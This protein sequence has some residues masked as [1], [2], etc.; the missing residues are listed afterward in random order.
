MIGLNQGNVQRYCAWGRI[1]INVVTLILLLTLT[2]MTIRTQALGQEPNEPQVKAAFLF[3]FVKFVE[4]PAE[5]FND[6]GTPIIVGV[7]GD[8]PS[9]SA[10][11]QT[12]NDKTANGRR[13]VIQRFSSVKALTYCHV[14]FIGYSQRANL[15]KILAV[16]GPR[17]LTVGETDRFAQTGGII[18][19]IIIDHKV[20][21]E[22][23]QTAA[24]KAG[25]RISAKLLGLSHP[26][27]R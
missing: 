5:A 19:F 17:V 13:L 8:D 20:R 2:S 21:F 15:Q 26:T 3:N 27:K 12:I 23:N 16:V 7:L 1:S 22:I 10:I 25:L 9:S 18:N 11:D 24:E 6:G 14:L 4:W